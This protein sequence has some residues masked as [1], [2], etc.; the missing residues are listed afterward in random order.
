MFDSSAPLWSCDDAKFIS[1]PGGFQVANANSG[2]LLYEV[3]LRNGDKV[4][5]VNGQDVTTWAGA[6]KAFNS[7]LGGASS[8]TVTV[9]RGSSTVTLTWTLV[10]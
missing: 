9:T 5:S 7:F 2:E 3:G 10:P 8:F 1:V 6:E 4:Q